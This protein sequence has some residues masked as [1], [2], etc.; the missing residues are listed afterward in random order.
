MKQEEFVQLLKKTELSMRK[1]YLHG[2]I[3]FTLKQV[4]F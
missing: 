2:S 4:R 1:G 3:L